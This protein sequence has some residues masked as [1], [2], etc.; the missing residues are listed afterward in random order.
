[1]GHKSIKT[2]VWRNKRWKIQEREQETE[3]IERSNNLI[4]IPEGKQRERR[5]KAI[6]E[7]EWL[8]ILHKTDKNILSQEG[9]RT[10][11]RLNKKKSKS[12][13]KFKTQEDY[14]S[15][16]KKKIRLTLNDQ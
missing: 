16:K 12:W 15:G 8:R 9:L 7:D 10:S 2:E 4:S 11:R 5:A 13:L 1:M 14:Q 3:D 6:F